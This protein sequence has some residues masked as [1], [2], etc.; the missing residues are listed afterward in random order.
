MKQLIKVDKNAL[1][2]LT[3]GSHEWSPNLVGPTRIHA[4]NTLHA[5]GGL[6][7]G[8]VGPVHLRSQSADGH[9]SDNC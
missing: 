4:G 9:I 7:N 3:E 1:S 6:G 2:Q 8:V 5:K